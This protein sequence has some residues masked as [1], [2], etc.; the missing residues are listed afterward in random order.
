MT[1]VDVTLTYE[2]YKEFEEQCKEFAE[3]T[4]TDGLER[5]FY[6]RSIRLKCGDIMLEVKGPMI[7]SVGG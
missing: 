4:H 2:E 5:Q 3:T 7:R 1:Q 6:H